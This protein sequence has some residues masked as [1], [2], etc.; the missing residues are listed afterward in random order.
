MAGAGRL[1]S[2]A[3]VWRPQEEDAALATVQTR[4]ADA[5]RVWLGFG[6]GRRGIRDY[7]TGEQV[8]NATP[9]TAHG[10][11]D[12]QRLDVLEITAGPEAGTRW[13]VEGRDA[14]D[15]SWLIL[16]LTEFN[17]AITPVEP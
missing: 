10:R 17:A 8:D 12:V 2:L 4:F 3:T 16:S 6:Q 14:S 11:A 9:A 7:G 15:P 5:G 13:K 1:R